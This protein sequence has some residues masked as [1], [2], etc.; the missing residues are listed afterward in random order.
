MWEVLC[1]GFFQRYV[2]AS[3]RVMDLGAGTCEFINAIR[4]AQKLAVDLNPDCAR[5]AI[6]A[7]V[8]RAMGSALPV[9]NGSMDVVFC[10][11]FFEHLPDK[12]AVLS[13]L[14]ECRRVLAPAGRVIILQPNIRYLPG[15]Y[16]DYFDHH[17]PLSHLSMIEALALSGFAAKDVIPRFLPYTVKD[18]RVP[19]S[20]ALLRTYLRLPP[21]WPLI[22]RQMLIVAEPA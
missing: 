22:G 18:S 13:T 2:R 12:G 7:R 20:A 11:N 9:A 21:L 6:D 16:W 10:S 19:R 15:R 5:F 17:T 8:V 14:R 3:D 1:E 4:C